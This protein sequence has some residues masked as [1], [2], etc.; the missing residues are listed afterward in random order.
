METKKK[1]SVDVKSFR[2]L[3]L[4]IGILVSISIVSAAFEYKS[5]A[6]LFS[7]PKIFQDDDEFWC[8][9]NVIIEPDTLPKDEPLYIIAEQEASFP[10]GEKSWISF[11][12]KNLKALPNQAAVKGKVFVSFIVNKEG[13]PSDFTI[14]R[15]L[16]PKHDKEVLRVMALSPDWVPARQGDRPV[17]SRKIIII[18]FPKY[19]EV[20]G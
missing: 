18:H 19:L 10:G 20:T 14:V 6:P 7:N 8:D 12:K 2:S 5:E 17:N 11:L 13:K 3:F 15:G 4:G 16:T 9:F 1:P